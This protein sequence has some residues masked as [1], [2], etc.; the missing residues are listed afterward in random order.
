M[1]V[2]PLHAGKPLLELVSS[3][4]PIAPKRTKFAV[5]GGAVRSEGLIPHSKN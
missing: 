5:Q 3:K 2:S 1:K 4:P